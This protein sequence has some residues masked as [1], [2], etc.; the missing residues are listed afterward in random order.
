MNLVDLIAADT[1]ISRFDR[2]PRGQCPKCQ[3][4]GSSLSIIP[5]EHLFHCDACDWG[6]DALTYVMW[7]HDLDFRGAIAWL[8]RWINEGMPF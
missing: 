6:G 7:R 5:D 3:A 2:E 8:Y 1:D 4:L